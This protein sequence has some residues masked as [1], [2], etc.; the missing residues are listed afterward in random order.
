MFLLTDIRRS[1]A[2]NPN[3]VPVTASERE[4]LTGQGIQE[5]VVQTFLA[6]RRSLLIFVVFS[7]LLSAGLSMWRGGDDTE[8]ADEISEYFEEATALI[9]TPGA[10]LTAQVTEKVN[11]LVPGVAAAVAEEDDEDEEEEQETAQPAAGKPATTGAAPAETDGEKKEPLIGRVID[12]IEQAP[13][14]LLAAAALAVIF[15]WTRWGLTFRMLGATFAVT[16]VLPMVIALCPWSWWGVEDVAYDPRTQPMQFFESSVYGAIEA[17]AMMIALLPTVLSLA[18]GVQ[19]ACLRVKLLSPQSLMPG[20]FLVLATPF[21]AL[22]L[23]VL[24][25]ALVQAT[26]DPLLLFGLL[27][28]LAA[29]LCYCVWYDLFTRPIATAEDER[30]VR[31]VQKL[32][33]AI[34]AVA[35]LLLV[36]FALRQQAMGVR[37]LGTDYENSFLIPLDLIEMFLETIGRAMF[38]TVLGADILMRINAKTWKQLRTFAASPASADYDR[39][40]NELQ[41]LA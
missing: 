29:P 40:M 28:F 20:W 27:L 15:L 8:L 35:G 11:E 26:S 13:K 41:R 19:K 25:I 6:W 38:M 4:S 31:G 3:A 10:A 18:P 30:K 9:P 21:Y 5:P 12:V 23:L 37:L 24:V 14:Y 7:T 39:A 2:A 1:F 34:T 16:F 17:A 36:F 22:F 33:G 32:V